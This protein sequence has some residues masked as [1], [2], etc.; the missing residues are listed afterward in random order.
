M[1]ALVCPAALCL[2]AI[3]FA[4]LA[5]KSSPGEFG[6]APAAEYLVIIAGYDYGS[7]GA[8]FNTTEVVS[9][10]PKEHPGV[11]EAP[12]SYLRRCRIVM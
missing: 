3:Q 8:A 4:G 12:L 10:F 9:L 2:L 5:C 7:A 6:G 1:L 11:P